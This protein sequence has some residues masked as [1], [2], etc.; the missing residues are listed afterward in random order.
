[1]VAFLEVTSPLTIQVQT[2]IAAHY[3]EWNVIVL[4]QRRW[5]TCKGRHEILHLETIRRCHAKLITD[6]SVNNKRRSGHPFASRSAEKMDRVLE[7]FVRSLQKSTHQAAHEIRLAIHT[8]H[9]VL[10]K[11]LNYSPWNPPLCEELKSADYDCRMEYE[12][13]MLSWHGVYGEI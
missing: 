11:E 12:E 4:V 5:S 6:G 1:M 8:A 2:K 9:S 3:E 7:M 10:H 13:L